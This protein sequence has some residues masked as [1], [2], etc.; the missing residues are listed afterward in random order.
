VKRQDL[1]HHG[2]IEAIAFAFGPETM[3]EVEGQRRILSLYTDGSQLLL[4]P[5][6]RWLLILTSPVRIRADLAP[7]TP[8]CRS[9]NRWSAE[10]DVT[11]DLSRAGDPLPARETTGSA[12]KDPML[13]WIRAGVEHEVRLADLPRLD[14]SLS[15]GAALRL[16][17]FR[18]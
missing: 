3:S 6:S 18:R 17:R 1:I 16:H 12:G 10:P 2:S 8:F 15:R 11:L 5:D 9:G 13:R 14:P 4:L 7:G